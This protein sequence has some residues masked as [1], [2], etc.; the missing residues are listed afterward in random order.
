MFCSYCA[1]LASSRGR[2]LCLSC[3]RQP[4]PA[5]AAQSC[6]SWHGG[7]EMTRCLVSRWR[8]TGA[9]FRI[10]NEWDLVLDGVLMKRPASHIISSK[11]SKHGILVVCPNPESKEVMYFFYVLIYLKFTPLKTWFFNF[12]FHQYSLFYLYFLKTKAFGNLSKKNVLGGSGPGHFLHFFLTGN[13]FPS[14]HNRVLM[15]TTGS[16]RIVTQWSK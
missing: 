2:S 6:D 11:Q 8:T 7:A 15:Y 1:R 5:P 9:M 3:C 4:G 16:G 10:K 12:S 14:V 13:R